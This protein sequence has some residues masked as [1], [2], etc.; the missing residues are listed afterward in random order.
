MQE[1]DEKWD[2]RDR[3]TRWAFKREV[4]IGNL[5]TLVALAAPLMVWAINL[6][7]RISLV[8]SVLVTQQR[9][10]DKQ[11]AQALDLKREIRAELAT[12]NAKIDRVL[13]R[14]RQ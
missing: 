1:E 7:K 12:L 14:G 9:A 4:S 3:R 6:D 5:L 2:G 10:D 13:E 8:E 11:E